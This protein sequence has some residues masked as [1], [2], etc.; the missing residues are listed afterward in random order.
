[1]K[2]KYS[3]DF[4]EHFGEDPSENSDDSLLTFLKQN[5][6]IAP[7]PAPNFEKQLFAEISKYPQRSPKSSKANLR[8]WLPWALLIPAAIAAGITFNWVTNRSQYQ[9]ASISESEKAEIE[10]SLISS[11]NMTNDTTYQAVNAPTS[12]DTQLLSDL[13]PL[14]YE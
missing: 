2:N 12:T 14:D 10:Q 5:K 7:L 9:M 8:R 4:P 6:P 13:S 3:Q 11:W 1:M